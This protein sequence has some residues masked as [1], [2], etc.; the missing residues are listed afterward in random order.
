MAQ[1]EELPVSQAQRSTRSAKTAH[2]AISGMAC[3]GCAL[4][5]E[6]VLRKNPGVKAVDVSFAAELGRIEFDP[7]QVDI[8]QLLQKIQPLGYQARLLAEEASEKEGKRHQWLLLRLLTSAAF[9]MQVMLLYLVQL[10]PLYAQ[11]QYASPEVRRMQYLVWA[12][13][14]P[15]LMAGGSAFFVAAW[16]ALR[17][18]TA[19]M[20][21]LVS[22][23]LL[24][25][26]GYS[27]YVTLAGQGEV[28]FD[29]VAMIT[30]FVLLGR[31]LETL[32]GAE[33]RKDVRRLL[34]LRPS[35]AWLRQDETWHQVQASSLHPGDTILVKPGERVPADAEIV[36]G[37]GALDE[38]LLTGESVPVDK[39]P[40]DGILAGT[41]ITDAALIA[42]VTHPPQATRLAQITQLVEQ[43]LAIKPPIQRLA[44]RASAYFAMGIV[45]VAV[46]TA[47]GW[48]MVGQTPSRALLSAVAVLVVACPCALGLATP[49]ALAVTL[50]RATRM[51]LLLRNPA[52]LETAARM[53]RIVFDKT[54]T[55]TLG[56]MSVTDTEPAAGAGGEEELLRLAASVEQYSEHPIARAIVHACPGAIPAATEFRAWRGL[57]AEA[58]VE[59]HLVKVGSARMF[60]AAPASALWEKAQERADHGETIVWVTVDGNPAG[61]IALRDEP[62]PTAAQALADLAAAGIDTVMLSGDHPRT[63]RA[64]AAELQ[65]AQYE[66]NC[67]PEDKAAR[68]KAWQ[69]AGAKVAMVGDGVND[70]PALAQ[71]DL[72]ITVAGGTDVAGETS[73]VVLNRADLTLVPWFIALSRRARGIIMQNLGW[74]FAYNLVTVPLAALGYIRPVIAAATMACSSLLVV[75][76]SL[77]LR[78]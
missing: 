77:R 8:S 27:V 42:R 10:Y 41:I 48:I 76:N 1:T 73:D 21:T 15:V 57:G 74:A 39:G 20:D 65:I 52:A 70:A 16:Q 14:T 46:V 61:L 4:S 47:I 75:A 43:T 51:G 58:S 68:I 45:A 50:G 7:T 72:S 37:H 6:R 11:G 25:A 36:E 2:F 66:G 54:G 23:G 19:T 56:R 49:L 60:E 55:L 71:A 34:Q 67:P 29:S 3:T 22:L 5:I 26:Y 9:G 32:G 35:Q 17:A 69:A 59:D 12:L 33:A 38:A 53:Q 13:A 28:Y 44:D 40:G 78:R 30:T 62:N 63:V 64:I 24:A 18:R 31:Y